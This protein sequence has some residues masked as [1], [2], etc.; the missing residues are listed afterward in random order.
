MCGYP[1]PVLPE[2]LRSAAQSSVERLKQE[3]SVEAF[4]V[5][6]EQA[7]ADG[8]NKQ[9]VRGA[10]M[11]ELQDFLAEYDQIVNGGRPEDEDPWG[12]WND[13][14]TLAQQTNQ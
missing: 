11:R 4:N 13:G 1:V 3:S 12:V 8:K 6:H 7:M 14:P 10:A 9:T 5:V 2:K